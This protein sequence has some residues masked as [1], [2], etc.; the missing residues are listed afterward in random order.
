MG[1]VGDVNTNFPIAVIQQTS[2]QGIVKVFGIFG[3]YRECRNIAEIL[4]ESD[5]FR[6]DG[7]RDSFGGSFYIFRIF[8][9]QTEL[10]QDRV[11]L[12]VVLSSFT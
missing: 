5:L 2:G 4:P 11:H 8:V 7:F 6:T 10:R 9:W 3:V 1:H 12:S